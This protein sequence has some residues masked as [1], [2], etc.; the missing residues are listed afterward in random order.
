MLIKTKS[1]PL[2]TLALVMFVLAPA[3]SNQDAMKKGSRSQAYVNEAAIADMFE[4]E[5]SRLAQTHASSSD[6]KL[7]AE[8]MATDHAQ[9]SRALQA[10]IDS[11]D[12]YLNLPVELDAKRAA[13]VA[14]LETKQGPNFDAAYTHIQTEAHKSAYSLH[15]NYAE[16][17][18]VPALKAVAA[19][20][21][22]VIEHHLMMVQRL[23]GS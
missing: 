5:T 4:V 20:A 11:S 16:T 17:G 18:D 10:A 21:A 2:A 19:E 12:L 3:C 7:F 1:F 9:T 8:M 6:V 23:P 13:L 14:E 22:P 15:K